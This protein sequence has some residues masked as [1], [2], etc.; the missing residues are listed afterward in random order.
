R[1]NIFRNYATIDT[2]LKYSYNDFGIDF[3]HLNK[4]VLLSEKR[5]QDYVE[6]GFGGY[7]QHILSNPI[8]SC[9]L[10]AGNRR[11]LCYRH[12]FSVWIILR[13]EGSCVNWRMEIILLIRHRLVWPASG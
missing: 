4:E 10:E 2:K 12:L 13:Q 3:M 6:L 7:W 9:V 1:P 8:V 5:K 11:V